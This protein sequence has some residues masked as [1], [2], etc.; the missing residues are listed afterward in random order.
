VGKLK[1]DTITREMLLDPYIDVLVG[2]APKSA[3][4]V[5]GWHVQDVLRI[6]VADRLCPNENMPVSLT[7]KYALEDET[8]AGQGQSSET[9][10]SDLRSRRQCPEA[11]PHLSQWK[12]HP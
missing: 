10:T 3:L 11:A 1:S 7:R 4:S 6:A 9:G 2:L 12:A 5:I 8:E